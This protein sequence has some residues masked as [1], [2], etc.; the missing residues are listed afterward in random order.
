MALRTKERLTEFFGALPARGTYPIAADVLIPKG[1][2]V[3]L[4]SSG[5]AVPC[6]DGTVAVRALGKSSATF[7]NRNGS[8]GAFDVESEFG[9]FEFDNSSSGAEIKYN[10]F[11]PVFAVSNDKV[12]KIANANEPIA[13]YAVGVYNGRVHVFMS[14][15][16]PL[17]SGIEAALAETTGSALVNH[18]AATVAAVLDDLDAVKIQTLTETVEHTDLTAT[19]LTETINFTDK[20]P[21]NAHILGVSARAITKFV[22]DSVTDLKC[23]ID[24][25]ITVEDLHT[26]APD[27]TLGEDHHQSVGAETTVGIKFTSTGANLS[28]ISAGS[29]TMDINYVVIATE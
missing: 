12:S 19:A 7:D 15:L 24:G 4:N 22:G 25:I 8:N 18:G 29:I 10:D 28:A 5:Y 9:V 20:L 11:C 6:D 14:P 13:G 27:V 21:K 1:T 3:A 23:E 16:V 17:F 2:I 26:D